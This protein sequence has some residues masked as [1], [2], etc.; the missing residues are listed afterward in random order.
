MQH[1]AAPTPSWFSKVCTAGGGTAGAPGPRRGKGPTRRPRRRRR[2]VCARARSGH[3]RGFR[4]RGWLG[5]SHLA[6]QLEPRAWTPSVPPA[7]ATPE[8]MSAAG[9]MRPDDQRASRGALEPKWLGFLFEKTF[10]LN[11]IFF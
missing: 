1:G 8:S 9:S 11:N 2:R 5:Q 7:T 6:A 10:F 4:G 3:G